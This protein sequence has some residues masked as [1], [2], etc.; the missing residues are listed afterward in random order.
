M[1]AMQA[2]K[3]ARNL[4]RLQPVLEKYLQEGVLKEEFVLDSI[5][6]LMNALREANVTLR[7]LMLHNAALTPGSVLA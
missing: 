6:K 4:E 1:C 2:S 7:W 3:Y 5:P